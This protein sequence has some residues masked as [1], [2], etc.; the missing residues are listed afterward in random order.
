MRPDGLSRA[1]LDKVRHAKEVAK[2]V[3]PQTPTPDWLLEEL[4]SV[5]RE[6]QREAAEA[7]DHWRRS[8]G[9]ESY[10]RYRATQDRADAAQ[11]VL[12]VAFAAGG[13]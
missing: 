2:L 7:Y 4:S 13:G 10:A 1:P 11:D 8:R 5:W 12:Q 6:A 3:D 9:S